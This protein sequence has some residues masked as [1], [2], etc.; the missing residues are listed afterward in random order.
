MSVPVPGLLETVNF[1]L[2][3]SGINVESDVIGAQIAASIRRGHPQ[4]AQQQVRRPE[5]VVL[6]G[7]G[8]SLN[9]DVDEIVRLVHG[10]A[11]LVTVNGSYA[12]ALERNL[13]PSAQVILDARADNAR[14]LHPAVPGCGYL[15]ASQC[16]AD[17]WDAVDGRDNVWIWHPLTKDSVHAPI[18]DQFYLGRWAP[19]QGG[20]TVISRAL[21]LL[22]MQGYLRFDVFGVDCC[23]RGDQH[24][25]F[26]QPENASD[27]A[28]T[29]RI[30]PPA[31]PE[32][33][34]T[35]RCS[36]WH[37]KQFE[38]LM[39]QIQVLGE[40]FLWRVHGDGLLA[41]ALETMGVVTVEE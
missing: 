38:D 4:L 31:A 19:V 20:C 15:L 27:V 1:D 11:K 16:H 5:S 36:L 41:Y 13:K 24:H 33:A 8:P 10:G 9:D 26:P 12:W 6:L 37:L 35:F 28:Y 34:R 3:G 17:V 18:L 40:H 29:V 2:S 22:R 32:L 7:S 30:E 23:W 14:F 25:A 39:Q 21:W